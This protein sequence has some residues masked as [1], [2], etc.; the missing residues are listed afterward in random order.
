VRD[1][2]LGPHI[3]GWAASTSRRPFTPAPAEGAVAPAANRFA[4]S[5][6]QAAPADTAREVAPFGWATAGGGTRGG[7]DA[8]PADV[9]TVRSRAEL[10]AALAPH[11]PGPQRPRIVQVAGRIDLATDASGRQLGAVDFQAPGFSWAAFAA[12]YAPATWGKRAPE[13][14][15]EDARRASAAAQGAHIVVRV[16]SRT[17]LIGLGRDATLTGGGLL[18]DGASDVIV[19]NLHL[20]HAFDHFPA[21]D[22]FDNGHGEWNAEYDT[23][24]LRRAS[25]VWIDHCSFDRLAPGT[26]PPAVLLGR[27]MQHTDGLLDITRGSTHVTVSWS[28]LRHHDKTSLV[29][30]SDRHTEDIGRLQISYHHVLWDDTHE[31]SPRV[32]HGQVHLANNLHLVPGAAEFGYSIGLGH[33]ASVL[34][35]HNAWLAADGVPPQRLVRRLGTA[36]AFDEQ[37]SQLNGRPL[38]RAAML[39]GMADAAALAATVDWQPPSPPPLDDAADVPARVRASAGAGKLLVLPVR[40]P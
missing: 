39:A 16:P 1:S 34:S 18:V 32:R 7:A 35:R 38:A 13:G 21:W 31:R 40:L 11:A 8:A 12:A 26:P 15:L 24:A 33:Q 3:G 25:R 30:G 14:P 20:Q 10:L 28:H 4:E 36:R 29:G 22:P 2:A 5:G 17:T 9:H 27:P 19:R 37:G 6:N 23:L